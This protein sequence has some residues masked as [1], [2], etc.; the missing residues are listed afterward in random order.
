MKIKFNYK[1]RKKE[2]V[3]LANKNILKN[4]LSSKCITKQHSWGEKNLDEF[5]GEF[6]VI[7]AVD[8]VAECY[9]DNYSYLLD[10]FENYC[11]KNGEIILVYEERQPKKDKIF[12]ELLIERN[13]KYEL[14]YKKNKMKFF[15]LK[16]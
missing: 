5:G 8:V 2:V 14:F 12:F 1:K 16:L 7:I 15:N 6:D 3:E 13:F 10:D 4:N 9:K 11:S